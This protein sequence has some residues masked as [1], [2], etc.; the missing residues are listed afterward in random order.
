MSQ[1]ENDIFSLMAHA[2]DLQRVAAKV[3]ENTNRAASHLENESARAILGA[4]RAGIDKTL[5]DT[6]TGLEGATTGLKRASEEAR[7]TSAILKRTGLFQAV[8]LVA[9]AIIL[10]GTVFAAMNY[11]GKSKL[12][13]L[14][15]LNARISA[16]R[17][18]LAEL[19]SK[20]W[21]LELVTYDDGTRVIILPKG[22]KV[23]RTGAV[24]DG[25]TAIVVTP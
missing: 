21:G 17:S 10:S 6:K 20:T 8:F 14:D 16:E 2:E 7:E 12:A 9:V 22:T 25:R 15:E 24:K 19:Q 13:D 3:L 18:A 5:Q 1:K 23:D 11:I 4:I